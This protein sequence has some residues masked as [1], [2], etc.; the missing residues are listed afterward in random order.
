MVIAREDGAGGKRLV[1]YVAGTADPAEVRAALTTRLPAYM[2][3]AAVVGIDALPLTANGKLDTRALPAPEYAA[4]VYRGPGNAVEE[5]LVGI[6]EQMLGRDRVG[7]DESFF[8]L[9]GDSITAMRLIAAINTS[10]RADLA[11]RTLFEAPT[12]AELAPRIGVGAGR[13]EPLVAADRPAVIPLSFAQKRLWFLEQLQGPSAVYNLATALRL[14]GPLDD[15]ALR[16]ALADV[17]RRHES[18]R[19]IFLAPDGVPQQVVMPVDQAEFGWQ[20]VDATGWPT[21]RLDDAIDAAARYAF[22]L[23]NEIPLGAVLFRVATDEHV[24]VAAVHHIASD[25]WSITPLA[26]DLGAAYAARCVGRPPAWSELPVQYADYTL[27]QHAQFG[28]LS[29]ADSPIAAQVA[30]WERALAGLP[31]RL[32]LPTDRPYPLVADQRGATMPVQWPAEL[33]RQIAKVA[34]EHDATSFMVVQAALTVLLS[35]IGATSDVAVGFPIAGRRDAA[36]DDLVGFF[37][38]TLPSIRHC[39][40]PGA[41]PVPNS[42]GSGA[43]PPVRTRPPSRAGAL[44]GRVPAARHQ[45]GQHL[46]VRRPVQPG[47]REPHRS[48][49]PL[50][51]GGAGRG[52]EPRRPRRR[53]PARQVLRH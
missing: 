37:V 14:H 26:R 38:N 12:I 22:D 47:A 9:G 2:V 31:E 5:I 23:A 34:R 24:L 29:D 53:N 19:T 46:L 7:V 41:R 10:L 11:V 20:V 39:P 6:Y 33:Q 1:G 51:G 45:H 15:D 18:L 25:G 17:V 21:V 32:Q 36:L 27:W 49:H 48:A 8:D 50:P 3:P 30:Y 44:H 13:L 28:D 4:G 40:A 35:K 42:Q 16:A 52:P 43:R